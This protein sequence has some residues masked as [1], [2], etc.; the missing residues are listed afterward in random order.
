MTKRRNLKDDRRLRPA[1]SVSQILAWADTYRE[2]TGNWPKKT[3]GRIGGALGDT[4]TAVEMALR[5]GCRGLSGSLST[6][7]EEIWLGVDRHFVQGSTP[8]A[9]RRRP[10]HRR[11]Q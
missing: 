8:L 9:D 2:R 7:P 11:A 10:H 3:S 1:L 6:A 5:Y 4:W